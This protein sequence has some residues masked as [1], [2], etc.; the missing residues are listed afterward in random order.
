M[1]PTRILAIQIASKINHFRNGAKNH[2]PTRHSAMSVNEDAMCQMKGAKPAAAKS[3]HCISVV[4]QTELSFRLAPS[5][6]TRKNTTTSTIKQQE[7]V[8]SFGPISHVE[9]A[10]NRGTA[11]RS[12]TDIIA[13][14]NK[15]S[16]AMRRKSII[17]CPLKALLK[18]SIVLRQI[19]A[20][21][22]HALG[23]RID[24]AEVGTIRRSLTVADCLDPNAVMIHLT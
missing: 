8:T 23:F 20:E 22:I 3:S 6:K 24:F 1:Y 18:R 16:V 4:H 11:Y 2:A 15:S 19:L 17:D 12:P 5:C 13:K 21:H 10:N 7:I 14:A 9:I